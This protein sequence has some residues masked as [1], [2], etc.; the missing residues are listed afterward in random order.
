MCN[1]HVTL[2]YI[3]NTF[4]MIW[5]TINIRV[6]GLHHYCTTVDEITSSCNNQIVQHTVHVVYIVRV[7][8]HVIALSSIA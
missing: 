5:Q 1:V 6:H 7:H 4:V 3:Y 8:V 2:Q